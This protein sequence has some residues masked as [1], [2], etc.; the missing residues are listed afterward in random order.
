MF[1]T[2]ALI[3]FAASA[4]QAHYFVDSINGETSCLRDLVKNAE[5]SPV[6][7]G[8][9]NTSK[10]T[11]GAANPGPAASP[12]TLAAGSTVTAHY[13]PGAYHA[14]PC[15]VYVAKKGTNSWAKIHEYLYQSGSWCSDWITSNGNN[16]KFTVPSGLAPGDYTFRVEHLGLHVAQSAG[17]AQ[18][19]IRCFDAVVT[20][21][22]SSTG[23]P[24]VQ[25]P[26]AYSTT[27]PGVIWDMYSSNNAA[28]PRYGPAVASFGSG[29]GSTGGNGG[30]V[31]TTTRTTT[32]APTNCAAKYGQCG[33]IGWTGPTCC[34]S[35]STCNASGSY[36]S[37]CI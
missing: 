9:I 3:A 8:D 7:G 1:K 13:N 30:G 35:G 6:T 29:G 18:F 36:Y 34:Q 5:N 19:Y 12:I 11:C 24:Q 20:G 14:G 23:S 27:T 25:F 32:V 22:G 33:G 2:L 10:I 4:V 16:Y 17:G 21:G 26:G 31:T 15:A 37:Q 28:Y